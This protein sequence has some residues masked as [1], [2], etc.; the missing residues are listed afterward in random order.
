MTATEAAASSPRDVVRDAALLP[1]NFD[2]LRLLAASQVVLVH[3]ADHFLSQRY[4][5][6]E[7]LRQAPGVPVFFFI[8]GFLISA[9][10][11]RNPDVR[12]YARNRFLRI[13]PAY[14]VAALVS[15]GGIL[16]FARLS[17][18]HDAGR[19][20]LWLA[21]QLTLLCDWNPDFLRGY[22]TGVVNGSLWTIPVEVGFYVLT[23]VLF[24]VT[25][26]SR[27]KDRVLALTALASFAFMYLVLAFVHRFSQTADKAVLLTPFPW[28]GQFLCGWL[29][30]RNLKI[31]LPIVQGRVWL[32]VLV[33]LVLMFLS[34]R[35]D[36][37]PF[38]FSGSRAIGIVNFAA[39]SLLVLALAYGRRDLAARLLRRNDL[40]Y[41]IYLFHMPV[42]NMLLANG[43]AGTL[44][45]V[46]T[47][48]LSVPV[49]ALSWFLV[50]K[51]LLARR[52]H[53]LY[54]HEAA[55]EGS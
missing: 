55:A 19:L 32:L 3:V 45:A 9:S 6:V 33:N 30:Q 21:A 25:R 20:A 52:A 51:P 31:L 22:G 47:A 18:P 49:A 48:A 41:G 15:L 43:I 23:P 42:A 36:L 16:L 29:A 50:E 8:S 5:L 12:S 10:W 13:Y 53:A 17:L 14:V 27:N 40:S 34:A 28:F 2:L 39:L 44:A 24:W 7:F 4:F 1:N 38:L 11:E 26:H 37:F 54:R 35:A 46:L